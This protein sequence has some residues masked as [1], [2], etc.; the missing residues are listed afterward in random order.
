MLIITQSSCNSHPPLRSPRLCT[1]IPFPNPHSNCPDRRGNCTKIICHYLSSLETRASGASCSQLHP[2]E[3]AHGPG[4]MMTRSGVRSWQFGKV[5]DSKFHCETMCVCPCQPFNRHLLIIFGPFLIGVLEVH[6][7]QPGS[8]WF[9]LIVLFL[10]GPVAFTDRNRISVDHPCCS[11]HL[12][13]DTMTRKL[14]SGG[15]TAPTRSPQPRG[16]TPRR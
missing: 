3:H 13:G 9:P 4:S 12:L 6:D 14:P 2:A 5:A 16:D 8:G 7:V 11:F 15:D 1:C 10:A